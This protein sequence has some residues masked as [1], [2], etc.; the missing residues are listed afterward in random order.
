[1]KWWDSSLAKDIL[2]ASLY[3]VDRPG[4]AVGAVASL[5]ASTPHP[6]KIL[7]SAARWGGGVLILLQ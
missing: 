3:F 2:K 7:K 5:S 4:L 6:E 1:M